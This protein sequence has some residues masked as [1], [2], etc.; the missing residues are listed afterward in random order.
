MNAFVATLC[1]RLVPI[2]ADWFVFES[3]ITLLLCVR[4]QSNYFVLRVVVSVHY[5]RI[6]NIHP[7]YDHE[8][9][10]ADLIGSIFLLLLTWW[11][12]KIQF[13]SSNRICLFVFEIPLCKLGW[14]QLCLSSVQ[15]VLGFLIENNLINILKYKD[16]HSRFTRITLRCFELMIDSLQTDR[17]FKLTHLS[18]TMRP[19]SNNCLMHYYY[20]QRGRR[21]HEQRN[22][23]VSFV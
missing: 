2:A 22:M 3:L 14:L 17:C 23:K 1:Q 7:F 18:F 11:I 5:L 15:K 9:H 21:A 13:S 10:G 6:A 20:L 19:Y 4:R 12:I 16:R 8:K